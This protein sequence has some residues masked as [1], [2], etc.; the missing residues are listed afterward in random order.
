MC[1]FKRVYKGRSTRVPFKGLCV[2]LK[3]FLKSVPLKGSLR[4]SLE[5]FYNLK[6]F[7]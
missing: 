7:L 5:G 6:G 3:G 1:S 2:S 4:G